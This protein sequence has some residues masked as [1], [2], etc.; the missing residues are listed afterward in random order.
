MPKALQPRV[1]IVED[2]AIVAED[3]AHKVKALGYDVVGVFSTG[4]QALNAAQQ[5]SIDLILLDIR[6]RGRLDGIETAKTLDK[7][8]DSAIVFTT[9]HSDPETLKKANATAP[10]GYILKPFSERDLAVQIALALHKR[11]ADRALREAQE[12]LRRKEEELEIIIGRTPFLLTRCSRD[13]RYLF[14][15]KAYADMLGRSSDEIAGKRIVDIMGDEGFQTILPYINRV[16]NGE[17]VV[18][19]SE[20]S[21]KNA[22]K[23][24]LHVEYTPEIDLKGNVVG[25]IASILDMTERKAAEEAVKTLSLF[26]AQNPAPVLRVHLT[27]ELLYE[28]PA[29]RSL[30]QQLDLRVGE[31]IPL[32]LSEL[33][34]QSLASSEIHIAEQTVGPRHYQVTITPIVDGQYVNL[35]WTDITERKQAEQQMRESEA[36]FRDM[37]DTAPV[38]IWLSDTTKLCIWFNQTWLTFT[39]KTM[40]QEVGNGWAECVHREDFERCLQVYSNAFDARQEFKMEYRLR[41]HDGEYRWVLDHG[42]PR[43]AG[44]GQFLG[45]IGSCIDISDRKQ[46]EEQLRASERLQ[47]LLAEVSELGERLSQAESFVEAVG[48][49]VA[50]ELGVSRCGLALVDTSA[51][52]ITVVS[53]Y[54]SALPSLVGIYPFRDYAGHWLDDGLSHRTVTF[55]DLAVDPRTAP[56]FETLFHPIQVRAHCTVPLHRAGRWVANFWVSHH[57]PRLW[58]PADVYL[59]E[60][61]AERVWD[62][63]QRMTAEAALRESQ[64][65]LSRAQALAHVGSWRL[66]VLRNELSWSDESYRIAGI[67]KGTP[68]TYES[69]LAIVHPDDRKY[70]DEKWKAALQGEPYD[71]EHRLVVRGEIRWAR[72]QAQLEFDARGELVGGFGAFHDITDQ[73][74]A[75]AE[76]RAAEHALRLR[77]NQLQLLYEL[78]NAV[79][80][81]DALSSLYETA[82]DAIV[83]CLGT[84]R[85]SILTIDED[86]KMRFQAWRGLSQSYRAA[87]EGHSPWKLGQM[88][89]AAITVPDVLA[90]DIEPT[91]GG[92]ILQEGIR[93]LAFI[94]LTY[95]GRLIGK[96][97]LY[98]EQPHAMAKEEIE[99][100][101]AIANTLAIGIE[102]KR[103]EEALRESEARFRTMAD[104]SPVI[105]WVTDATGGI[106]FINQAYRDFCG[107][108][109]D[110]VRER[111]WQMVV[112][113]DDREQYVAEFLRCVRTKQPFYARCRIKRAD[114]Q[115]R[116]IAS[117]GAPRFS[118]NGHFL[119]HVGSSP[120]V[121][122]LQ[123]AQQRL[124]RWNIELEEA[125]NNK[126]AELLQSQERLRA[127]TT[128]LNLAEQRERKRLAAELHDH[129][130]QILVLGKLTIG[131]G[132]RYA[133]GLPDCENVLKK[134]DDVLVD[135]LTYTRTLVADLSPPALRDHGLAAGLKW[136]AESM[137]KHNL[138]VTMIVPEDQSL[139]LP[140][141][142]NVLLFQSVRELLINASKHAGTGQAVVEISEKEGRLEIT[143]RDEGVGFDLAAAGSTPNTEISSKFGLFSIRERMKA[144]GGWFDIQ[145]SPNTGTCATLALPLTTV[146]EARLKTQRAIVVSQAMQLGKEE[147]ATN[148]VPIRVL[149]VDDHAMVRQGLRAILEGYPD[150]A[151][152]GNVSEATEATAAINLVRP[153][154]VIMDINMPGKNGIEATSDMKAQ[155]PD[156]QIIGLTVSAG[157]ENQ[158]AMLKA[159]AAMLLT[160]EAVVEQLHD[161]IQQVVKREKVASPST[162]AKL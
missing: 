44:N 73:K 144:M 131:Q 63:L 69:F 16:L 152:V 89:Y 94:P 95:R 157:M 43:Y 128:E 60:R 2:E 7:V 27:G 74:R 37:A 116:W 156:I 92:T 31:R 129:L 114:G 72:E 66:N 141:D 126:T 109:D 51:E 153:H 113:P 108:T 29:S 61:L 135:A 40:Q 30:L 82:L 67:P 53:D 124:Q 145:S 160:K 138:L 123:E 59:M 140:E 77:T 58:T 35:Y 101:H 137:K 12:Q 75:E 28:N 130:Q 98:F 125:V 121:Q 91:L 33:V 18:Y 55:H 52:Q 87:V 25:W 161:A 71:I 49:R 36:R 39:G 103:A 147:I 142:H 154:V 11:R 4:E 76:L 111:R 26:P 19:E 47:R 14:V 17:S 32:H 155:Y 139:K 78:A 84:N 127:L 105:I 24:W 93:A 83:L 134:L 15:S 97:M 8:C 50:A 151:V 110:D 120:D 21:F 146:R 80:R 119:G 48:A 118:E 68:L 90:S 22:G 34:R 64:Q 133:V 81:A 100:A 13:L 107:V 10:L 56:Q 149:L 143:V 6:L 99:M 79:N 5:S 158:E 150:I 88:D 42:I 148:G 38:L 117:Y 1:L 122:D 57:K 45:Y 162:L 9:A 23:R 54:H 20:V 70:V 112:H 3:L 41:R 96:F 62:I 102:R 115:W 159:G 132:K 106:K 85:G 104:V 86:G 46:A 136:L 65:D